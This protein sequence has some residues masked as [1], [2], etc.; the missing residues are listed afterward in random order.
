MDGRKKAMKI[1][2]RYFDMTSE[3]NDATTV[4]HIYKIAQFLTQICIRSWNN[5]LRNHILWKFKKQLF[6]LTD[7][8]L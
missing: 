5:L 6:T 2:R 1:L 4:E 3:E 7:C 8:T